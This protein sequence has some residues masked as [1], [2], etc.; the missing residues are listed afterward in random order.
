MKVSL[1]AAA[2]CCATAANVSPIQKVVQLLSD[3]EAKVIKEGE[4]TQKAYEEF[5]EWCE[6]KNR[7]LGF[8]IKTGTAQVAELEATISKASSQEDALS[9]EIEDLGGS[10]A[11]N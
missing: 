1:I 8:E 9:Q 6:D 7:E 5:A 3:L 11:Q 10:I 4:A 2:A